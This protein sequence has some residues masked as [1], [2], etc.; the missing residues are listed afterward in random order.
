MKK[1]AE[2]KIIAH[3]PFCNIETRHR[4]ANAFDDDFRAAGS[5]YRGAVLWWVP[6]QGKIFNS[7]VAEYFSWDFYNRF[8]TLTAKLF[9]SLLI[10]YQFDWW[11][12]SLPFRVRDERCMLR[13]L[14][15]NERTISDL[16]T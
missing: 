8:V 9:N 11:K 15:H 1:I 13:L 5:R 14:R 4:F 7:H 2:R 6:L 16:V 12:M 3:S 10:I